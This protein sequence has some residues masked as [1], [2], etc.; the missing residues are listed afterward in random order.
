[1]IVLSLE[2]LRHISF[3]WLSGDIRYKRGCFH[4]NAFSPWP[5]VVTHEE[6]AWWRRGEKLDSHHP[7][8]NGATAPA[9]QGIQGEDHKYVPSPE[10]AGKSKS[11]HKLCMQ[12]L[13]TQLLVNHP[14][15]VT[16]D[17]SDQEE[18]CAWIWRSNRMARFCSWS[19]NDP[20]WMSYVC[21]GWDWYHAS[22]VDT[23]LVQR[24]NSESC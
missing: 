1:M 9:C 23:T 12:T 22:E 10:K 11:P 16:L 21:S 5:T 17:S 2:P 18:I 8:Q 19:M 7:E 14:F 6:G 13:I 3:I 24:H 4:I 20:V 15:F